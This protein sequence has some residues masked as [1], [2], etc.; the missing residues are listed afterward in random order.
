[1]PSIGG[2]GYGWGFAAWGLGAFVPSVP[3]VPP[4]DF[5]IYCFF[6]DAMD[7]I[8]ED[9]DV[10]P[11][12]AGGQFAGG[13]TSD[14]LIR[15]GGAF[16]T[17]DARLEITT[18]VP[19]TWTF[20]VNA[21]FLEL[22]NDFNALVTNH[23]FFGVTDASGSCAGLFISKIGVAYTGG[24]SHTG[25]GDMQI[26]SPIEIL[27]GSSDYIEEGKYITFR[28]AADY[29][30]NVV[31]VYITDEDDL[32]NI[33]HQLRY[34]LPLI[35]A[36]DLVNPPSDRT[37]IS[38][39]GTL[40]DSAAVSF[41][42]ICLDD[43]L[44]IPN[45]PPV[46]DAGRD[47]ASR[48]CNVVQ[49]DATG[50]VDPENQPLTYIW[51]L[52]DA[53]NTSEF[54]FEGSDGVTEPLLTPTGFTDK[55]YT[56]EGAVE[57]ALDPFVVGDVLLLDGLGYTITGTAVDGDGFHFT[58]ITDI[59][60]DNVS[61]KTF[62]M[63][64][65]RVLSGKT[66]PK[67]T[68]LP[69]VP[70][71][72]RFDLIVGDG[73]LFSEP[74]VTI[75]NVLESQIPKGCTPDLTFLWGYLSDFWGLVE[76]K[77]RVG[78]FFEALTQ[79]AAS[80]LL[81]LWQVDY[82]KS[83]RDIQRTFQR[84][85][86]HYDLL[87]GEPVP[88]LTRV[89]QIR[90]G[91][92][93]VFFPGG[94]LGGVNGTRLVVTSLALEQPLTVLFQSSNPVSAAT[95]ADEL[96]RR[97]AYQDSRFSATL[98]TGH[99]SGSFVRL[100]ASIPFTI[101]LDTTCPAFSVGEENVHPTGAGLRLGIRTYKV[102][103]SL[104]SL[105]IQDGDVIT[106]DGDGYTVLRVTD[107]PTDEFRYQRVV[108]KNDL[109]LLPGSTWEMSGHV[110]SR[111]LN[112]YAGLV[113][114]GD[115]VEFEVLENESGIAALVATKAVGAPVLSP[116]RLSVDLGPVDHYLA[117]SDKYTVRLA[118]VVRGQYVP[119]D[120]LVVDVP[121][122]QEFIKAGTDAEVLR[123]NVDYFLEDF[124]GQ[125]CIRFV[126]E[127]SGPDVWE[128][129]GPPNRLWAEITFIDNR[130]SIESNFGLAAEF[131]L[132]DL[133]SVTSN[134][135]YLSA[136]RGLWY[137]YLNGPTIYN[138]RVG[139]QILLGLPFAEEAGTIEEI[140][141]DFSPSQGR[142]LVRDKQSTAIVRSYSYPRTLELETNPNT[143]VAYAVGDAVAQFAP[144][145]RGSEILDWLNS[146]NWY[147][148]LL[149]Q[150]DFFEIE[151]FFRFLVR[152]DSEAFSL[153]ALLFVQNLVLRIKPNYTYPLFTVRT[154]LTATEVSV[155]DD[156]DM[157][158]Y[159]HLHDGA[160]FD[161]FRAEPPDPLFDAASTGSENFSTGDGDFTFN[162]PLGAGSNRAVIVEVTWEVSSGLTLVVTYNG[163]PMTFVREQR[164]SGSSTFVQQLF[165]ILEED[166]PAAGTYIVSINSTPLGSPTAANSVIAG[167]ISFKN[168][169]Q[170]VPANI[171]GVGTNTDPADVTLTTV[172]TRSLVVD[173]WGSSSPNGITVGAGQTQH[174]NG[175]FLVSQRL[176]I[177]SKLVAAPALTTMSWTGLGTLGNS[178][179]HVLELERAPALPAIGATMFDDP[180]PA[181][182]GWMNDFDGNANPF[183]PPVE[184]S[185]PISEEVLWAFDK[186]YLCPEDD[187]SGWLSASTDGLTAPNAG[188][189]PIEA[190]FDDGAYPYVEFVSAAPITS[191]PTPAGATL[192]PASP[193]VG[194]I[195]SNAEQLWVAIHGFP[196][197][198]P[199]DYVL[200]LQKNSVDVAT[201]PF[202]LSP[203]GFIGLLAISSP[204]AYLS[205]DTI[206]VVI[207]V[208]SGGARTPNLLDVTVKVLFT[209]VVF[210][211]GSPMPAGSYTAP[212]TL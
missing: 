123:R 129:A 121:C 67:P 39:R 80:E 55:F 35:K 15:S 65:Q 179:H 199:T 88:E 90:G 34:V 107:D 48:V 127:E 85:W 205:T 77:E 51:R 139:T 162:H 175:S 119:V 40:G 42:H 97:I 178:T 5:D 137:A 204:V 82:S 111:L 11:T 105:G 211:Y 180:N 102:D 173:F 22:P 75:V 43:G 100:T 1:M 158:G 74:S 147:E 209:E 126:S 177:S 141:T 50:S 52:I 64:R 10:T 196:D 133:G 212:V 7:E 154:Q 152:I 60:P 138:L 124:R 157:R 176:A 185:Y 9:D 131:T 28:I 182:G 115:K 161:V 81:T 143:G 94:G 210:T 134:I 62:K 101:S 12:D 32:P 136:V 130:P 184:D 118:R 144:L 169:K 72:Y 193:V 156:I 92:D 14:L 116:S 104:A 140:R 155:D 197:S 188:T 44:L 171:N 45:L 122:L 96:N 31:Y 95:F 117:Q 89:R 49:L 170:V 113:V 132:D 86:L 21:N 112:F 153:S 166:L 98:Q 8:L 151:K 93:T 13:G 203:T 120:S 27:A 160:C 56:D 208:A 186:K 206:D 16:S 172:G 150:G 192:I 2:Y 165:I 200:V 69:D 128:G 195:A 30:A 174:L 26:D 58:F 135:D 194:A 25:G 71:I 20:Q 109:P 70:G 146:P 164:F 183:D 142:I 87:L 110:D 189:P 46:A 163:V 99:P 59:V 83:L 106:I 4:D 41:D 63:L 145:V 149:N 181:G 84:R 6:G 159:L 3:P 168:V 76:D 190:N 53:P 57:H 78:V 54:S 103:R 125:H 61:N 201:V 38:I 37:L 91:V 207:R 79:V 114:A 187:I 33:G 47:Q 19:Q 198:D 202:A 29:T 73:L 191:V 24:I 36:Q 68:F 18:L 17:A 66:A 108:V 148:G 167:A 23:V